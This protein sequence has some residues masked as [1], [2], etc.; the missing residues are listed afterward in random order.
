MDKTQAL[1]ENVTFPYF[2]IDHH[3]KILSSS[4]KS[5]EGVFT[6]ILAPEDFSRFND[7]LKKNE[8]GIYKLKIDNCIL[9]YRIYLAE[10]DAMHFHLFCFPTS[11]PDNEGIRIKAEH[12]EKRLHH[13]NHQLTTKKKYL[14]KAVKEVEETV[15]TSHYTADVGQLAAGIAH[16]IRNPLTTVKGFIQLLKPYLL[17]IGKDQYAEI[18]IEEINR[19][20]DMIYEFLNASK[21]PQNKKT[22]ISVNNLIQE[23][24]LL[25]E[26]EAHF[27]NMKLSVNICPDNPIF[28]G[29]AKQIK[30][31]LIN[32]IKNALEACESVHDQEGK[33]NLKARTFNQKVFIIIEDNGPGM[34]EETIRQLFVPF[35]TTKEK[36]T[37]IGLSICRKI[38]EEHDGMI[39]VHSNLPQGTVFEIELPLILD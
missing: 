3:L 34:T 28:H 35:Y 21:P 29:D 10:D 12:M 18:A 17:E 20:N 24:K 32:I 25:F 37:G 2:F 39:N 36:G 8:P 38:I 4:L 11:P 23:M 14:K 31:V 22:E 27:K 26:S 15:L 5:A 16:E 13:I 6:E 19:A 7:L 1:L 30:Q 9:P 33:I